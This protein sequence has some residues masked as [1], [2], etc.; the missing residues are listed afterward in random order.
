MDTD[1][2][3]EERNMIKQF[4]LSNLNQIYLISVGSDEISIF[5]FKTDDG[6]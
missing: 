1:P 5:N 2:E 6:L 3:I 4:E